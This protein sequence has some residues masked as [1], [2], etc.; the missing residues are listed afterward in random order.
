MWPMK[1]TP[2]RNQAP[3]EVCTQNTHF[4]SRR[5]CRGAILLGLH[6][7]NIY[8][9]QL[10]QKDF[11]QHFQVRNCCHLSL[12]YHPLQKL[13]TNNPNSGHYT[14]NTIKGLLGRGVLG[15]AFTTV[16][17]VLLIEK[18]NGMCHMHVAEQHNH[19]H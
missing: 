3:G 2:Q 17:H 15:T 5:V 13:E 12:Q 19:V 8:F 1:I 11:F 6:I 7:P 14:P 10:W 9:V 18:L 4:S 16:A